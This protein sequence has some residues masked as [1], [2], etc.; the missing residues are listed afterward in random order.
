ME[1]DDGSALWIGQGT[2]TTLAESTA[3]IQNGGSHGMRA[4]NSGQISLAAGDYDFVVRFFEGGGGNG[5]YVRWDD[6]GGTNFVPIPGA[7]YFHGGSV[8]SPVNIPTTDVTLTTSANGSNSTLGL[9]VTGSAVLGNLTLA[10]PN[11]LTFTTATTVNLGNISVTDNSSI[12]GTPTVSQRSGSTLTVAATKTLTAT[13][14]ITDD[15]STAAGINKLGPGTL[16]LNGSNTFT[17]ASTFS[18][19]T[20]KA[21]VNNSLGFGGSVKINASGPTTLNG[22]SA[23]ATLELSNTAIVNEAI[24]LNGST[25]GASLLVPT[26]T[27]IL[28]SGI[29]EIN[30]TN[31]GTGSSGTAGTIT[32]SGGGGSGATATTTVASGALTSVKMTAAGSG[33]TSLPTLTHSSGTGRVATAVLSSLTLTG[34]NNNIGGDGALT[35]NA[36][37]GQSAAGAGFAKTGAGTLTLNGINTYTG[38]TTVNA[39]TLNLADNAGLSFAVTNASSNRITGV[40]TATLNGDFTIDTSAVNVASGSWS[41][42]DVATLAENFTSFFTVVG[43]TEVNNVWTKVVGANTWVFTEATGVLTLNGGAVVSPYSLWATAQGLTGVEGS[44]SS[45]DPSP[46]AD[47]DKDGMDNIAEFA[48]NGN[49]RSGTD[50]G[51]MYMLIADSNFDGDSLKELILTVAVRNSAV[52]T[53]G[54]PCTS[55]LIDGINYAIDGS[56]T[57]NG[58]PTTV[59]VVPTAVI[60]GLPADTWPDY[61]YRSFSLGTSNNLTN[62]G[63]LRARVTKP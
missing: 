18:A 33:Y 16:L 36:K 27:A 4:V 58:F 63:Y 35:I 62:K 45:T 12:S 17:G 8:L 42:V 2:A 41:L 40:G 59:N 7:N 21:A 29:A 31:G 25:N 43:F 5:I 52:F 30:F 19:G 3:N 49:P 61:E 22:S 46:S 34:T 50:R 60:T 11:T 10:A 1:S 39:G 13:S 6:T 54:A 14:I 26:G 9:G 53:S 38:N 23:A 51:K 24:T 55:A 47:P 56:V 28:G 44:G 48:F 37:I 57:L 32:I 20:V 15:P